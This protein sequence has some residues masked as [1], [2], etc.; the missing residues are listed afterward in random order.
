MENIKYEIFSFLKKLQ[1]FVVTDLGYVYLL[2][3]QLLNSRPL[4][5]KRML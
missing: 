2:T 5:I 1:V 4:C 3:T